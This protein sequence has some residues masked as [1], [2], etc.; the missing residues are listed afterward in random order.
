MDHRLDI[1]NHQS[2]MQVHTLT[3]LLQV[4]LFPRNQCMESLAVINQDHLLLDRIPPA[5]KATIHHL[6]VKSEPL[7]V[8]QERRRRILRCSQDTDLRVRSRT[9]H[10]DQ[11]DIR[12]RLTRNRE[13]LTIQATQLQVLRHLHLMDNTVQLDHLN[14]IRVTSNHAT[15]RSSLHP[16]YLRTIC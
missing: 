14:N 10:Q 11:V 5:V 12:Q 16:N 3:V 8:D 4:L 6:Q 7:T 2:L 13:H 1:R 9:D 15:L